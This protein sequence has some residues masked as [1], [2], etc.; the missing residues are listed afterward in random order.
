[1]F[2]VNQLR[3]SGAIVVLGVVLFTAFAG[4]SV[5]AANF[6][7]DASGNGSGFDGSGAWN[8]SGSNWWNGTADSSW[9]NAGNTAIFGATF[10]SNPYTVTLAQATTASGLTFANQAYTLAGGT[11]T[12]PTAAT[13]AAN[14]PATINSTIVNTLGTTTITA[15]GGLT[16]GGVINC[17]TQTIN[18]ATASNTSGTL[19]V[20]SGANISAASIN[21][22]QNS[23]SNGILNYVQTGGLVSA[24]G[25]STLGSSTA[26]GD[27]GCVNIM[28]VSGGTFSTGQLQLYKWAGAPI[29]NISGSGLVN[30]GTLYTGWADSAPSST[31][32]IGDGSTFSGGTNIQNGGTSGVL[33]INSFG[34]DTRSRGT[35]ALNFN[36]GTLKAGG[37]TSTLQTAG[38]VVPWLPG[39]YFTATVMDAGGIIDNGGF[40]VSIGQVFAHGGVADTDG[41][42][43]FQG[44]GAT[45]LTGASTY[46]GGTVIKNGTLLLNG[47][48]LV[49]TGT[50]SVA[51]G[52]TFGGNGSA[53]S[54]AVAAGGIVQGGYGGAAR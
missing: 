52:A 36:G 22:F 39:G 2:R 24:T 15:T 13:I 32:N 1:M 19:Q 18:F 40:S 3:L 51:S 44:S 38:T 41:G 27:S 6:T 4:Q 12:F 43:V 9:S 16:L 37:A 47:G 45:T 21:L 46:N 34:I 14:A 23:V 17:G 49:S 26:G 20:V 31:V 48:S 50:V 42:L 53:D 30:A 5:Q 7:W 25:N 28:T 29:L 33:T 11:L 10:G 35:N 8:L 54:V